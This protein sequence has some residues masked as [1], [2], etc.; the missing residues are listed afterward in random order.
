[1][2]LK[3]FSPE[4]DTGFECQCGCGRGFHDMSEAFLVR[5]DTARE[6]A[7]VPF[8]ITSGF[9]CPEHN[10][11]VSNTGP[12]GPH[13]TGRAVDIRT[14]SSRARFFIIQALLAE[15]F[16]R[17]GIAESFVHVDNSADHPIEVIWTYA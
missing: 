2:N 4:T 14:P 7:R 12:N 17:I 13:T 5:L 6:E 10:Q 9:R 8:I 3:H 15:G 16:H 11:A 1:M